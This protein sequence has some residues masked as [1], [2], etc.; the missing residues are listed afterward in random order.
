MK[1]CMATENN[2]GTMND[3]ILTPKSEPEAKKSDPPPL[4]KKNKEKNKMAFGSI[5]ARSRES[6][7]FSL[8]C[9]LV[10]T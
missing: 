6:V 1:K 3:A 10:Y 2:W 5:N 8:V 4:L 7:F 9:S